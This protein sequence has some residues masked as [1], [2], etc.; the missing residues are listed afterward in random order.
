VSTA[1]TD[2]QDPETVRWIIETF[3]ADTGLDIQH[4]LDNGLTLRELIDRSDKLHNSLDLMEAF[5]RMGFH[6]QKRT[7]V[8][9]RL[10][11]FPTDEKLSVVLEKFLT[12]YQQASEQEGGVK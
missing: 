1:T 2:A 10:P 5:A 3:A 6:L 4:A 12:A 11:S 8:R 7:G 9:V